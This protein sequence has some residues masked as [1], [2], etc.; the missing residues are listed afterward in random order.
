VTR[1]LSLLSAK[2]GQRIFS[3]DSKLYV[4]YLRRKGVVVGENT[5]FFGSN[6]RVDL[7]RPYLIEICKNC[8]I[9]NGV[10]IVSHGYDLSVLREKYGEFLSSSGKVARCSVRERIALNT[11]LIK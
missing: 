8:V 9:T 7:S 10:Q 4:N 11:H 6:A 1:F 2:L 3:L 5:T